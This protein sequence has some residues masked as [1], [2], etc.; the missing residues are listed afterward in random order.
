VTDSFSSVLR[1]WIAV[2]PLLLAFGPTDA[3]DMPSKIVFE[4]AQFLL[5]DG[6]L[7]PSDSAEWRPVALPDEWRR[8]IASFVGQGW[9]RIEFQIPRLPTVM[10]ALYLP[11]RRSH[12]V[13]FH[14]NGRYV[15]G[16]GFWAVSNTDGHVLGP[17]VYLTVPPYFLKEGKNLIHVRMQATGAPAAMQGLTRV[18]FGEAREVRKDYIGRIE[19]QPEALRSFFAVALSAGLIALCLWLAGRRERVMLLLAFAYLSWA[20]VAGWQRPLRWVELPTFARGMLQTYLSYG[21]PP[22]SFL[23]S[24]RAMRLDWPRSEATVWIYLLIIVSLPLWAV[25]G[26][27]EWRLILDA[28]NTAL[29][30]TAVAIVAS[31][32]GQ[33]PRASAALFIVTLLVMAALICSEFLR[34][35]GWISVD[36]PVIRHFHV[37]AMFIGIGTAIFAEYVL[38]VWYARDMKVELERRIAEKTQEIEANHARMEQV[39]REQ[40]LAAERQRIIS[41]MH[42]G[43]GAG[44]ISLLRYVQTNGGDSDIEQRV[45]EALLELRIAIDA[46][47]VTG[48]DVATILGNLRYRLAP[49]LESSKTT[50]HWN[51]A[52]LPIVKS[53][54]PGAVFSLQRIILE[55]VANSIRHAGARQVVLMAAGTAVG[56]IEISITDDGS[57]FDATQAAGPGIANMQTHAA[58]ISATLDIVSSS[59]TGTVVRLNIPPVIPNIDEDSSPPQ[60]PSLEGALVTESPG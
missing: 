1:H 6:H 49:L 4:R 29:L 24:L 3:A 30:L 51:V 57:G 39:T 23:L 38:T 43:L 22:L 19:L 36:F 14:V 2:I 25:S 11:H 46:L 28:I 42:D 34:Y 33:G 55:A 7:P 20:F 27:E 41:D 31:H 10:H 17:T 37:L 40:A 50:L 5:S 48:G 60:L 26:G 47:E 8:N 35:F 52:K 45:K 15:G 32:T 44:L 54:E 56:G 59:R 21:L 16:S 12:K 9:Y 53:L 13:D 58:R 18:T